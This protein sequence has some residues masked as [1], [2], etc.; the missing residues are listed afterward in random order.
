MVGVYLR[1]NSPRAT[2]IV[3]KNIERLLRSAVACYLPNTGERR[4]V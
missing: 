3:N 4:V 1:R 2:E